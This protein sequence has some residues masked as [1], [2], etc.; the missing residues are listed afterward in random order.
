MKAKLLDILFF[1]ASF[2]LICAVIAFK[3]PEKMVPIQ[4][5]FAQ[6]SPVQYGIPEDIQGTWYGTTQTL[7]FDDTY[8]IQHQAGSQER[9][10]Q[11]SLTIVQDNFD[12]AHVQD[13]PHKTLFMINWNKKAYE[14]FYNEEATPFVK[15]AMYLVYDDQS[16][17]LRL[18]DGQLL[19]RQP[20]SK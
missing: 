15:E 1:F 5:I 13:S 18:P 16:D 10:Y 17:S 9:Q 20:M 19:R 8:L 4:E 12:L 11:A 14:S 7:E 6:V 2:I 3:E